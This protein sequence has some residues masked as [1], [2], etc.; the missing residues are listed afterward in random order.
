MSVGLATAFLILMV[1]GFLG[2]DRL[3][4][5]GIE[6]AISRSLGVST[7]INKLHINLL[8]GYTKIEILTINNPPDF[9]TPYLLEAKSLELQIVPISLLSNPIEI[10]EFTLD[11]LTVNFEQALTA[12]NILNI[13]GSS[14]GKESHGA[15]SSSGNSQEKKL[16]IG[17]IAIKNVEGNIV[18]SPLAK[19]FNFKLPVLDLRTVDG[20]QVPILLISELVKKVVLATLGNKITPY[21]PPS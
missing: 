4:Q 21:L 14:M 18:I 3:L 11:G 5:W 19:S 9:S 17:H 12:N 8:S 15:G 7:H 13:V 20:E 16:K 2:G 6:Q 10:V 1:G